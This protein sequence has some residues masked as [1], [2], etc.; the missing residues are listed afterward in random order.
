M[1]TDALVVFDHLKHTV[2]I[3]ANADLRGAARRRAR[4]RD[5]RRARSRRCARRSP[6]RCRARASRAAPREAPGF[7]V[8]HVARA[9]SKRWSRGSSSTSTPATPSR[10]C[11]RSAGRRRCPV[12]AFSIYRGLRA[13]NPS[14]YM[15]FLDFG[16]FQIAGASPEPLLTVSGRHVSHQADRGHAPARRDPRGGPAD[17]RRAARR[18]E[19]ARRARDARRPRAQRPRPRLRVRQRRASTS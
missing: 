1:L 13:V 7:R 9:A 14:P 18:R 11:P 15:Y 10:S 8:E 6:G 19:G 4:L 5:G 2:T 3:L 16:D 12:E 17:R